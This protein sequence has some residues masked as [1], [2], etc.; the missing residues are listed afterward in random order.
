MLAFMIIPTITSMTLTAYDGVND[1]M[2]IAPIVLGNTKTRAIYKVFKKET[3]GAIIVA[4][5]IA[6]ARAIG[7]TMAVN[8]ILQAQ[9]YNQVF[10]SGFLNI[11]TSYLKTLG[12]LIA[13][14][15]F[16]EGGGKGL[17]G[18]LFIYGFC[19]FIFVMLLNIIATRL[20]KKSNFIKKNFYQKINFFF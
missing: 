11:T 13:T 8:M 6:L 14:N 10:D 19:L 18:L 4:I 7:E 17:Q 15:M 5:I 2:L 12:S 3:Y 16:A 9:S 1:N 20:I